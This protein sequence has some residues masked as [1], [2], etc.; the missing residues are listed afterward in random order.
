MADKPTERLTTSEDR[1][2]ESDGLLRVALEFSSYEDLFSAIKT[3]EQLHFVTLYKRSSR[4]IQ[5]ARKRAPNRH[6]ADQLVYSKLDCTCVH[7]GRDYISRS[8][9]KRKAQRF[10]L[11]VAKQTMYIR[12]QYY[13][14]APS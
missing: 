9:G 2:D 3:Y 7:G 11:L 6:F 4:T 13:C 1:D 5:A 8:K 10:V 14:V 12:L